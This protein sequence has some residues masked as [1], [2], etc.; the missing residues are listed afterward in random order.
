MSGISSEHSLS[1]LAY[2]GYAIHRGINSHHRRL[3]EDYS[4]ALYVNEYR[5][6]AKIN[7][8]IARKQLLWY[9]SHSASSFLSEYTNILYNEIQKNA[10]LF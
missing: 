1:V 2:F 10:I 5:S 4:L 8:D 3:V 9:K 7:A 6:G